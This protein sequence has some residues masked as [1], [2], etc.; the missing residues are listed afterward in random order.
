MYNQGYEENT[1]ILLQKCDDEDEESGPDSKLG[2]LTGSKTG[3][4][5]SRGAK[6]VL[7]FT[8]MD[9]EKLRGATEMIK[10]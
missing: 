5:Y 8:P 1:P 7:G 9:T 6:S 2:S 10:R 3:S 4:A